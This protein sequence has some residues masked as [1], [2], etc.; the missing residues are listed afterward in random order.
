MLNRSVEDAHYEQ[1]RCFLA[2]IARRSGRSTF[3]TKPFPLCGTAS[4][5][6]P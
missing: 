4:I 2:I 1:L 5:F 3:A 6:A